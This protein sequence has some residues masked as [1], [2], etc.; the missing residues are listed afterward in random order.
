MF[1]L[2]IF[3]HEGLSGFYQSSTLTLEWHWSR[4]PLANN[5]KQS[6]HRV[7]F[8]E[9]SAH[10][11]NAR[12]TLLA[13]YPCTPNVAATILETLSL[14]T[15]EKWTLSRAMYVSAVFWL[16]WCDEQGPKSR[17][18]S[19]V[20][21][22]TWNSQLKLHTR[23]T[24]PCTTA[25]NSAQKMFFYAWDL[26]VA[27][28]PKTLWSHNSHPFDNIPHGS[29]LTMQLKRCKREPNKCTTNNNTVIS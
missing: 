9:Q 2:Y 17:Q 14:R 25:N 3:Y 12:S 20:F 21:S 28:E 22:L 1:S 7:S 18:E 4:L 24:L 23:T 11:W 26:K 8:L 19:D 27:P 16:I 10:E 13:T 15:F 6:T 5:Q 29:V